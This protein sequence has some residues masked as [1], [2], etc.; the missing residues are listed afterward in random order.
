MY[1]AD[2]EGEGFNASFLVKKELQ[3]VKNIKFGNWDGIHVVTCEI[4]DGK[5]K[6]RVCSTV[7]I[8]QESDYEE[9]GKMSIAGSCAKTTE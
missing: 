8:T 5:A 7:M 3:D 6:Y 4:A 1:F 2:T 9:L